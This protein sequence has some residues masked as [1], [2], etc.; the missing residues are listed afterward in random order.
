MNKN[1]STSLKFSQQNARGSLL[2][3]HSMSHPILEVKVLK[4]LFFSLC[5]FT[6]PL[7]HFILS[8]LHQHLSSLFLIQGLC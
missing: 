1:C 2:V 3:S 4:Y 5:Q 7:S 8:N 6:L